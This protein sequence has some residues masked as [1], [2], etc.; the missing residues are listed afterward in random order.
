MTRIQAGQGRIDSMRKLPAYLANATTR[1]LDG[2]DHI[3]HALT[4]KER[5]VILSYLVVK[6][7]DSLEPE[8]NECDALIAEALAVVERYA[9]RKY[10]ELATTDD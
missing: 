1:L 5:L 7:M 4:S 6:L 3:I 10:P 2:D 9:P 8:D